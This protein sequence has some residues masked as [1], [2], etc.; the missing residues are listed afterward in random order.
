MLRRKGKRRAGAQEQPHTTP[1][2]CHDCHCP[3]VRLHTTPSA[4]KIAPCI[5]TQAGLEVPESPRRRSA[6]EEEEKSAAQEHTGL[7]TSGSE[8]S[9]SEDEWV[10]AYHVHCTC[11]VTCM[12]C[13]LTCAVSHAQLSCVAFSGAT[14][15]EKSGLWPGHA[16]LRWDPV[17]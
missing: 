6:Q 1:L 9:D 3:F 16:S 11:S 13:S 14:V 2:C 15:A 8:D 17:D 12:W 10:R 4:H 7:S 5:C